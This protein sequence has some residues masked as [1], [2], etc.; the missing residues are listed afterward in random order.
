[1]LSPAYE[2][3]NRKRHAT[4]APYYVYRVTFYSFDIPDA[5]RRHQLTGFPR[6]P[7][8]I[9]VWKRSS[10]NFLLAADPKA[11]HEKHEARKCPRCGCW[12]LGIEAQ[13]Q[14][15]RETCARMNNQPVAPCDI[16]NCKAKSKRRT[17]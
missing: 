3:W 2:R 14:R 11:R 4:T 1:V 12:M 7:R 5:F 6:G 9:W 13:M 8:E 17:P 16:F 15:E 10:R